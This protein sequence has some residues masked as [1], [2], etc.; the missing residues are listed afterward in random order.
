VNRH[1][2][3]RSL[4]ERPDL[5]QL[6]RQ[7]KELLTA[8]AAGDTSAVAEVNALYRDANAAAFALHDAQL[9]LARAYG[10]ESWPKLKACVDGVTVKRLADAVRAGDLSQVRG[11]LKVRPELAR[12]SVGNLQVLH[13]AVLDRAPEMVRLLM[14]HGANAREGVYPHREATSALAIA[15]QRGYDEIVSIILEKER[16]VGPDSDELLRAIAADDDER[17]IAM[18]EADR[19]LIHTSAPLHIAAQRL[20][21][22]MVEWLLDRGADA[23]ARGRND[24][25]ALDLAAYW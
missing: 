24:L 22:R 19:A 5:D 8:F 15:T 11:M 1:L 13:F 23:R 16:R 3:T 7:A 14:E 6:K 4:P 20:N 25:T 12:M 10:F 9:V 2:P 18:M 21:G 17:A